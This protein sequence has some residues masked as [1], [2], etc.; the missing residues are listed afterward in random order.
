[1]DFFQSNPYHQYDDVQ[2]THTCHTD[3]DG[4][5]GSTEKKFTEKMTIR[6]SIGMNHLFKL[7]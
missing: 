1:M 5:F 7:E 2:Q 4:C 3:D 6:T